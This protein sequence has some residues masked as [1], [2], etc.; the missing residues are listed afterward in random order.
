MGPGAVI[1]GK[2][3]PDFVG[4]GLDLFQFIDRVFLCLDTNFLGLPPSF[5]LRRAAA[6]LASL[7][8]RPAQPAM[9]PAGTSTRPWQCGQVTVSWSIATSTRFHR[10]QVRQKFGF[11]WM[12]VLSL[13]SKVSPSR[14]EPLREPQKD[15]N[16]RG[17]TQGSF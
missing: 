17:A 4:H 14:N 16:F 5:P 3:R 9:A 11:C 13:T 12:C 2:F 8:W 10:L 7:V 15:Q 6:A 1:G